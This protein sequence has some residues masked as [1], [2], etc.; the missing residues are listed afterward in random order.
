VRIGHFRKA[1][2]NNQV[3]VVTTATYRIQTE[4][5]FLGGQATGNDWFPD[6][7]RDRSGSSR[8][9]QT[10]GFSPKEVKTNK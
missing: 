4:M 5:F 10:Q 9:K 1:G 7:F 8:S 2:T 3:R 6:R